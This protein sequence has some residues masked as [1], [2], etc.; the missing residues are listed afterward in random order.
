MNL[1][2]PDDSDE[3]V[4]EVIR[5]RISDAGVGVKAEIPFPFFMFEQE[6]I[7]YAKEKKGKDR[8]VMIL[9]L[10]ECIQV[11]ASMKMSSEVVRA[12]L[13]YFHRHNIFLY[14]QDVLPNL[15][16]LAPQVP[17]DFVNPIVAFSYK[18]KSGDIL[19]LDAECYRRNAV[20]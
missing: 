8:D 15:V 13:I 19:G 12:A 10:N 7:L 6:A 17:L 11:G 16:F 18:V 9:S 1:L 5:Q 20:Q 3:K 14:F 4:L 2:K